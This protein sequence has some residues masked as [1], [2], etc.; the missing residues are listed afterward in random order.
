MRDGFYV[1]KI[2]KSFTR[3]NYGV[4]ARKKIQQGYYHECLRTDGKKFY[5]LLPNKLKIGYHPFDDD[6][7]N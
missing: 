6:W 1:N 4:S 5:W 3:I 7:I 2:T